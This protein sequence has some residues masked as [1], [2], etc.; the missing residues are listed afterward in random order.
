MQ[1]PE[2]LLG[3]R[4]TEKVDIYGFGTIL[5]ELVTGESPARGR[6]RPVRCE[7]N[8]SRLWMVYIIVTFV[9][10]RQVWH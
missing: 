3:A 1:A 8:D 2:I 10:E 5:W 6:L 4:C 9:P 7:S